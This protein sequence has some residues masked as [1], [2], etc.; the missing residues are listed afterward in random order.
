AYTVTITGSSQGIIHTVTVNYKVQDFT[1]NANP[2]NVTVFIGRSAT[3]TITITALQGFTGTVTLTD[4]VAP[5]IGLTCVL[6][7]GSISCTL[8]VTTF[9]ASGNSTLSCSGSPGQYTVTVNGTSGSSTASTTVIYRVQDFTI[10]ASPATITVNAGVAGTSTIT[11]TALNGFS[12]TI[13]LTSS[14]SPA[15]GLSCILTPPSVTGSGTS[16]LSCSGV[17]GAYTVTITRTS[18]ALSHPATENFTVS[19]F[20]IQPLPVC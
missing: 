8:S 13:S 10:S 15:T 1:V 3:S 11:V 7:P 17:A 6:T 5:S 18:G 20:T 9:T 14:N 19:E 2:T 4:T 16:T 12:G